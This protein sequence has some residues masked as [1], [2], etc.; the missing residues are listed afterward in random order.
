MTSER[1]TLDGL[2]THD[3]TVSFRNQLRRDDDM[4]RLEAVLFLAREPLSSRKLAQ[5]ADLEDGSQVRRLLRELNQRY[6]EQ[7]CAFRIVEV[8]GGYQLRTRAQFA[9]WLVRL[10]EVPIEVRL[11]S[12]T[13]ETLAIVAYKQPVLRA[14]IESIRGVQC[15]EVLRQLSEKNLIKIVGRSEELG[16][17]F[18]YG[19][20]PYFLQVFGLNSLNDLREREKRGNEL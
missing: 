13:M 8:G 16:R 3:K 5:F 6:D 17:P 7:P 18:L 9:P 1:S 14:E 15:G 11:S 10:Q 20:T 12:T 4:A 19:T 2:A